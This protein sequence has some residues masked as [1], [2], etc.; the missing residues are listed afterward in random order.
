M[1]SNGIVYRNGR[2]IEGS[3]GD[4]AEGYS[5]TEPNHIIVDKNNIYYEGKLFTKEVNVTLYSWIPL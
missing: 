5:I 1:I 4:T 2:Q 3:D